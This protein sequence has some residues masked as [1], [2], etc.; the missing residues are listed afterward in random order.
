MLT[1][2]NDGN[3]FYIENHLFLCCMADQYVHNQSFCY[4]FLELNLMPGNYHYEYCPTEDLRQRY[5]NKTMFKDMM[6]DPEAMK[7]IERVSPMLM[8]FLSTGNQ[9][10]FYESI[11]SLEKLFYMGFT[12]EIV[13]NLRTELSKLLDMEEE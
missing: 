4:I 1:K 11:Q 8:Y 6:H 9:D 13:D 10:Y 3:Y 12:R 5:N 2:T 7:V